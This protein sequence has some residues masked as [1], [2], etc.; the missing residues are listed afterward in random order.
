MLEFAVLIAGFFPALGGLSPPETAS[1]PPTLYCTSKRVKYYDSSAK[2]TSASS[3]T[4][5]IWLK[6]CSRSNGRKTI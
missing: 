5:D 1:A 6:Y 4:N 2:I 3:M